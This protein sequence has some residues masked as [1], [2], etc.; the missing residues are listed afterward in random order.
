M[1]NDKK[2]LQ[3]TVTLNNGVS[4]PIFG[5]GVYKSEQDTVPAVQSALECGYR[6]IDTASFYQNEQ[7]VGMA[8]RTSGIP[9]EEIFLTTKLWNDDQR[10]GKQRRAFEDSLQALGLE[11]VDLYLVHWPIPGKI[12]ETWNVLEQ[13]Y[14]EKLVRAIGV[15]N[16]LPHHLEELSVKGNVAPAVDQFE[17]NPYLTRKELRNYCNEHHI[18]PEAWSPLGRGEAL[19]DPVLIELSQKYNKSV[20]QIILRYDVQNGIVT[21]PK[22]VRAE[23]IRE[24][25]DIFDFELS[26]QDIEKIDRL[27][28]NRMHG[29]PDSV[30]F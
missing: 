13:L 10:A 26:P 11:Y 30:D 28:R 8:V 18:V 19:K 24:N 5:L 14:E 16:F 9:R 15:S 3:S 17:C 25:A 2:N 1:Q 23:R 27:N 6:L 4:M 20:A 29:D 21:I 22:S 7:E 12:H